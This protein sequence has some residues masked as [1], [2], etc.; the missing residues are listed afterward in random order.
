MRQEYEKYTPEDHKVWQLLFERQMKM[1]PGMATAEYL[2]G[3]ERLGF[4][5]ARI[6][7][8]EEVNRRL[9]G[10]TGWQ[11]EVV[12]G[13]LPNKEFFELM[14]ERRFPASTWLRKM[15]QLEYLEEP[16]MFHDVFGHIPLLTNE[17]LCEFLRELSKIILPHI[18]NPNILEFIGRLYWYS[19]EF[20]LMQEEAGLRIYGAGVLSSSGESEYALYS[21]IPKRVPYDVT[22]IFDTR[23][24]KDSFQKQYFVIESFEQ[25]YNSISEIDQLINKAVKEN[26][27]VSYISN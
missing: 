1:L 15:S 14:L 23:Y 19:I 24:I 9:K 6:P 4:V 2:R 22:H 8:I 17:H 7:N 11:I 27:T 13:L 5:P 12:K 25:L 20:G 10:Y 18:T 3:I 16:D 26:I 21:D